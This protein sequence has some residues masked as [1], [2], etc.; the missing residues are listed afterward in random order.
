V[1]LGKERAIAAVAR[2]LA[3]DLHHPWKSEEE[4]RPWHLLEKCFE[5]ADIGRRNDYLAKT[6]KK[7]QW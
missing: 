4:Y 5:E 2:K 1:A 3:V 6:V 7:I